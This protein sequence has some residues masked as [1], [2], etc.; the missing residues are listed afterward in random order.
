MPD[1]TDSQI[2]WALASIIPLG[3]GLFLF[4]LKRTFHEFELKIATLFEDLK[5]SLVQIQD[6]ETRISVL[7]DRQP[8]RQKR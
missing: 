5:A 8:R 7:E 6:H 4:L 1:V 2:H 3:G